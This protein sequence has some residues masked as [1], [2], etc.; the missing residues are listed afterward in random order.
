LKYDSSLSEAGYSSGL[1]QKKRPCEE[2]GQNLKNTI[3]KKKFTDH[4]RMKRAI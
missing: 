1:T 3:V 4:M 2:K